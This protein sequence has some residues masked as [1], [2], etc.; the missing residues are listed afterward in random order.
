VSE[1]IDSPTLRACWPALEL[2][3]NMYATSTKNIAVVIASHPMV[4]IHI[5][6]TKNQINEHHIW[7]NNINYMFILHTDPPPVFPSNVKKLAIGASRAARAFK[8][9]CA[10]IPPTTAHVGENSC[11]ADVLI[12]LES[13]RHFKT[14]NK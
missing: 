8:I 5:E 1:T 13:I 7:T 3:I 9:S 4:T 6:G 12:V 11:A 2:H 10:K 14:P